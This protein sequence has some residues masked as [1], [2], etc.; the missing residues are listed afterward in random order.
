MVEKSGGPTYIALVLHYRHLKCS[1]RCH[2]PYRCY[3]SCIGFGE[4]MAR[5][6]KT[7]GCH[8]DNP[9]LSNQNIR[10]SLRTASLPI[11]PSTV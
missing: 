11:L 7:G 6:G 8:G 3:D 5:K 10:T 9:W 1:Y 2:S 4:E